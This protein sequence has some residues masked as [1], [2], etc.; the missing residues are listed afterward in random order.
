MIVVF[1]FIKHHNF[2]GPILKNL[3]VL[4][5][6]NA[7]LNLLEQQGPK[8]AKPFMMIGQLQLHKER[9]AGGNS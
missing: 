4:E 2:Y 6:E 3:K 1:L 7:F 5:Q 8:Y 9:S